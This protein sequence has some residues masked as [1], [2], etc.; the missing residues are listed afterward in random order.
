MIPPLV[1][2]TFF[3]WSLFQRF[4][5]D[6]GVVLVNKRGHM[7]VFLLNAPDKKDI[8][9]ERGCAPMCGETC[10]QLQ[11]LDILPLELLQLLSAIV[12]KCH[13]LSLMTIHNPHTPSHV[14]CTAFCSS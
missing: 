11:L 14:M 7:A 12:R 13:S 3:V 8:P 5:D 10:A 2:R 9:G 4:K 6:A 1:P